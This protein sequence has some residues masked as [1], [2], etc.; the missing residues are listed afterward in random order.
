MLVVLVVL[1]AVLMALWI[2]SP[3][4]HLELLCRGFLQDMA[5]CVWPWWRA[6]SGLGSGEDLNFEM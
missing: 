2:A 4:G 1:V 5:E 6:E 3:V